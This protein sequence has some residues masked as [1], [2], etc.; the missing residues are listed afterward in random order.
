MIVVAIWHW[1]CKLPCIILNW[2]ELIFANL[3]QVTMFF[4]ERR[5]F[6][7]QH[8]HTSLV[9]S[10]TFVFQF[11]RHEACTGNLVECFGM[12]FKKSLV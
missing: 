9:H 6:S 1:Q 5:A 10:L 4:L 8:F 12:S 2:I 3:S 7:G 11:Y